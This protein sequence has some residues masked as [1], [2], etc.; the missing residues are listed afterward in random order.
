[1]KSVVIVLTKV[2]RLLDKLVYT[3]LS[4]FPILTEWPPVSE[5][6]GK[7]GKKETYGKYSIFTWKDWEFR[8]MQNQ[9]VRT[10]P[11]TKPRNTWAVMI[12]GDTI[13]YSFSLFSWFGCNWICNGS[14]FL[15]MSN[16]KVLC[17]GTR[18]PLGWFV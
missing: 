2:Y 4:A 17:S 5:K 1:M 8:F 15:I 11:F 16:F 6:V 14:L 9:M 13:F 10:I 3:F 12:G 7:R 18:F